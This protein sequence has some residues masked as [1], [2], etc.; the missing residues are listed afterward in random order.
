MDEFWL[1]P[2][3]GAHPAHAAASSCSC[4][5]LQCLLLSMQGSA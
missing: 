5:C 4:T 3:W 2:A 1:A